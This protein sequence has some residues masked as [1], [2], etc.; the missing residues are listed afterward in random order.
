M[1]KKTNN[2]TFRDV[3]YLYDIYLFFFYILY[4]EH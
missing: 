4:S 1:N 2:I 3:Y